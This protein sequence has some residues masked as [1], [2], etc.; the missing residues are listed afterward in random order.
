MV[1]DTKHYDEHYSHFQK[2]IQK[3]LQLT[4][5]V[6]F[7]YLLPRHLIMALFPRLL[8]TKSSRNA[9]FFRVNAVDLPIFHPGCHDETLG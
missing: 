2:G 5:R 3:L 1:S 7:H 9:Q 6:Y 8:Y 4:N